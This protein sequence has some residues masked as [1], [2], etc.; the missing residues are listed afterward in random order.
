LD[1]IVDFAAVARVSKHVE[2]KDIRLIQIMAKCEPKVYGTLEPSVDVSCSVSTF[3]DS[4]I[5]VSCEYKFN[6]SSAEAKVADAEINYLL[7]YEIQGSP[8]Q[9]E[10]SDIAEFARAN[11]ALHSWPFVREL[12]Y[13]LTSKMGY[14]PFTLPVMHFNA[15]TSPVQTK[16]AKAKTPPS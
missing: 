16:T 7:N 15:K 12:L 9:L 1:K 11:G 10:T 4:A 14:P 5:E 8:G 3:T 13:A 2:L 6:V